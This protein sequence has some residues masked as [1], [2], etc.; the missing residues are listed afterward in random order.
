M[1]PTSAGEPRG[2]LALD[3]ALVTDRNMAQNLGL[4]LS[5]I[6]EQAME[7]LEDLSQ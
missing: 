5:G 4:R 3:V 2:I 7:R 1:E 6:R